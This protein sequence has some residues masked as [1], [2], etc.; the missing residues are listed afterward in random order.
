[1]VSRINHFAAELN[2]P[3]RLVS[4][5][6][7]LKS[8]TVGIYFT[9]HKLV[10][11]NGAGFVYGYDPRLSQCLHR[12][13]LLYKRVAL[14]HAPH[15]GRQHQRDDDGQTLGDDGHRQRYDRGKDGDDILPFS[16]AEY[17]QKCANDR[18]N[19]DDGAG[20]VADVR[21]E[22]DFRV[23]GRYLD[24]DFA[25]DR[26]LSGCN[27]HGSAVS[28]DDICALKHHVALLGYGK[29]IFLYRFGNFA[30]RLGLSGKGSFVDFEV[31]GGNNTRIGGDLLALLQYQHI[32][33]HYLAVRY[34][35][36]LTATQY[37]CGSL[38]ELLKRQERILRLAFLYGADNR[39]K[40]K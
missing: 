17:K 14:G 30:H 20:E 10:F 39:V 6:S 36:F 1:M 38:H 29:R 9:D 11:S 13:Q 15:A 3:L 22:W 26:I 37:R 5:A 40:Q 7:E 25:D 34:R 12:L 28:C 32:A 27:N 16:K 21:L 8:F 18:H 4:H 31:I 23:D 33:T 35:Q 2:G 24:G 19:G